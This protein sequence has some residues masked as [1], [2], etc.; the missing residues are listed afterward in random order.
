MKLKLFIFLFVKR[1]AYQI[2]CWE[3]SLSFT[4]NFNEDCIEDNNG[5]SHLRLES[6]PVG[7]IVNHET[8]RYKSAVYE[9]VENR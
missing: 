9:N 1:L 3:K 6:G 4:T 8:L 5:T 7:T 2:N